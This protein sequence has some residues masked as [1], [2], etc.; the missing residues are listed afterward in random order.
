MQN[1]NN[2][3]DVLVFLEPKTYFFKLKGS[4]LINNNF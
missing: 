1:Y 2:I 3:N 4:T